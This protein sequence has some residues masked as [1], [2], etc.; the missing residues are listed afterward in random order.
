MGERPAIPRGID[1]VTTD[2]LTAAL[3]HD[4]SRDVTVTSFEVEP[5]GV[6]VGVMAL[7]YRVRLTYEGTPGPDTVVL[8]L[9]SI[10]EPIRQ[11]AKGYRFYEREVGVYNHLAP[12]LSLRSPDCYF[13]RH[14]PTSD[15]FVLM[16][17]DLSALRLADQ[18]AGCS[19]ADALIVTDALAT[20]HAQWFA[21]QRLLDYSFIERPSDP[22]Y[23][24][25][26]T[27]A[28]KADWPVFQERFAGHVPP[29][30]MDLGERW[31]EIGP[32]LMEETANHPWTLAHGDVR[33]DNIF[34]DDRDGSIKIVDWQICFRNQ[35]AFDLAYFLCQSLAVEDRR[36]HEGEILHRYHDQIVAGGVAGYGFDE[37]YDDYRRSVLFSFCYPMSAGANADLVNDRVAELVHAMIDRS[38][39][40]ILDLD[41]LELV[42]PT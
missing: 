41:A 26:H 18:V 5:I 13:A 16:I 12:E 1:D 17:Q 30:L 31:Y 29:E 27:Q 8:K 40:A 20:F 9:A 19:V 11:V 15:D 34:F 32:A 14:D 22:P 7:L 39:A 42:P 24:Q 4:G 10:H 28:T 25:Y 38:V 36:A 3:R 6:G 35:G 2:W 33:L 21:N 23:P 37:F